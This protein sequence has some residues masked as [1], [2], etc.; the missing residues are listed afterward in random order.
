MATWKE[1]DRVKVVSREV[2]EEDRKSNR[3]YT[4]MAGLIGTVQNIYGDDEVAI[5]MDVSSLTK[6]S[7]SVHKGAV[8]RM[9][10]KFLGSVSEEQKKQLTPEELNFSAN[11][12]LLC[13]GSDIEKL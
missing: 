11:F 1:G 7:A 4:H 8:E 2:T 5:K 13:R 3:Y 12:V 6:V 9:R 10:D